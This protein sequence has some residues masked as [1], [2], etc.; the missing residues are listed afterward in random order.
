MN[1]VETSGL[2]KVYGSQRALDAVNLQ[3]PGGSVLGLVG[4]NGAGKTTLLSI[5]AGL[6]QPTSGSV[7]IVADHQS[8]ATLPDTP[9][10]EPW[11]TGREVVDL[12]RA[13]VAPSLPQARVDE[14]LQA[15]G[16]ADD[17][18]RRVGG[19]SRGMLQ[20]LG[21]AATLVGAPELLLLDEPASAL[22]PAGRREV[23]D[24]IAE[25]RGHATVILSSHILADVQEVADRVAILRSGRLVFEGSLGELLTGKTQ[26]AYQVRVRP[27]LEPATVALKSQPWVTDVAQ[28]GLDV[29]SVR[30]SSLDE[31]ERSLTRVLAGVQA[32]VVSLRPEAPDLEEV[33][34][35]VTS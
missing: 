3:V 30:V 27:P 28:R 16:L 2:C 12:A 26:P 5:L 10:F 20:R 7:T 33:F 17:R 8:I 1:A 24:L 32:R 9:Q 31:A 21:L 19:Y 35:E 23:L 13:L 14:V 29:L 22:D 15:A 25:L 11:L 6:R 18:D 34:L 4:P